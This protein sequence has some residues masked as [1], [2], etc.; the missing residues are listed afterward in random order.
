[1]AC[2][3]PLPDQ[4][5]IDLHSHLLPGID[6]GCRDVDESLR[7]VRRLIESGFVGT[8]C[9]PHVVREIYPENVPSNI[10]AAV[11]QLRSRLREEEIEYRLWTGGECRLSP[12]CIE[13]FE[14]F[15][16]P[17]LAGTRFVLVDYFGKTW[18]AF[19]DEA[20]GYLLDRDY[21]PILAH[22][23]RLGLDEA[24]FDAL[25][26][27]LATRGVLLQGN[28]NSYRGGEGRVARERMRRLIRADRY[29]AV[30]L[31][32]HRPDSLEPRLRGIADLREEMGDDHVK[33][34]LETRQRA[35]LKDA[36]ESQDAD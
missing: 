4:G 2:D 8:V 32:M 36:S 35:V 29:F 16:V 25:I 10:T 12:I 27:S 23:E 9:T 33:L 24:P 34:L 28:A 26:E 3:R 7:C 22:P 1:M 19:A 14:A 15:G 6:D 17:T 5:R 30:A 13:T 11:A 20:L 31:D 21:R 18:P